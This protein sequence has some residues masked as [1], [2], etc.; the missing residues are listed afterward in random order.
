[1]FNLC[2]ILLLLISCIIATRGDSVKWLVTVSTTMV[3]FPGRAGYIFF[4]TISSPPLCSTHAHN[5]WAPRDLT[6]RLRRPV[7]EADGYVSI[8]DIIIIIII[9]QDICPWARADHRVWGSLHS[10]FWKTYQ[11]FYENA[12]LIFSRCSLYTERRFV[13]MPLLSRPKDGSIFRHFILLSS[14]CALLA[15]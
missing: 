13:L 2:R 11:L 9:L 15:W 6:W 1:M 3:R 12:T 4:A 5:Q 7:C 14:Y 8:V 10:S